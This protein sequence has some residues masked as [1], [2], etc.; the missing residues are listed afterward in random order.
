MAKKTYEVPSIEDVQED[1]EDLFDFILIEDEDV[2][3]TAKKYRSQ[4]V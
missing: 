2:M 3:K 1:L 4:D